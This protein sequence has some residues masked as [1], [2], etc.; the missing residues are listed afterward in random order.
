MPKPIRCA[1][2][3]SGRGIVAASRASRSLMEAL[4]AHAPHFRRNLFLG[5]N[6]AGI[7]KRNTRPPPAVGLLRR[8]PQSRTRRCGRAGHP[9]ILLAPR[10]AGSRA[11]DPLRRGAGAGQPAQR[12]RRIQHGARGGL[13][14]AGNRHGARGDRRSKRPG[15]LDAYRENFP[16]G[17]LHPGAGVLA[18]A[19]LPAPR[20]R[21]RGR[22]GDRAARGG[23]HPGRRRYRLAP[24]TYLRPCRAART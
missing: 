21:G 16:Q 6:Y 22:S 8:G 23:I 14:A 24:R 13:P 5:V 4:A 12:A 7:V 10:C 19:R 18:R 1:P 11:P 17:R 2:H 20:A 9:R 3:P 15:A